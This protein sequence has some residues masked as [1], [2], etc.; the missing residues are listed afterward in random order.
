MVA[1]AVLVMVFVA[2]REMHQEVLVE[3]AAY[4]VVHLIF[5]EHLA[6]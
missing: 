1:V 2:I 3:L 6:R 5:L 4:L